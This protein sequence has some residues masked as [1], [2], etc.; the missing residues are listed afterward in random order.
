MLKFEGVAEVGEYIKAMDFRHY[1]DRPDS[2]IIGRVTEK[3]MVEPLGMYGYTIE[4]GYDTEGGRVG[5]TMHVPYQV[6]GVDW[7]DR[8]QYVSEAS[9]QLITT[10]RR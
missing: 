7:D 2:F 8:V 10:G 4:V 3:G 5:L 6:G 1:E 9:Y